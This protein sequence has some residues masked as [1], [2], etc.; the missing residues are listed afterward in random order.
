[1][2]DSMT[3][4]LIAASI[5]LVVACL[6]LFATALQLRNARKK[7]E[8]DIAHSFSERIYEQ[9]LSRYPLGY[10]IL[11]RLRKLGPPQHLPH[12]DQIRQIKDDLN[13]W[14]SEASLF[15]SRDTLKAYWKLRK[16]IAKNPAHGADYSEQQARKVFDARNRLRQQMRRDMG[17]LYAGDANESLAGY[18]E[19]L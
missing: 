18:W 5:S 12:P 14:A 13:H 7:Q 2:S 10:A 17:N 1:M 6:G 15:F 16:A 19:Y 3:S 9:R 11:S 4:A 8:L